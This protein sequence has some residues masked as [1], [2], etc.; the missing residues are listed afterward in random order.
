MTEKYNLKGEEK[1]LFRLRSLYSSFGY[2]TYKMS[3]F[4]EYDLY[5]RNKDFLVSSNIITFN[6]TD[7]KLLALKPDVTL[8]IVRSVKD[9]S[10]TVSRICYGE[11][12]Y[13][14]SSSSGTFREIMQAGLECIGDVGLLELC[15]VA[16]LAQMSL[17]SI[18]KNSILTISHIGIVE[19]LLNQIP[20]AL[21]SEA[22]K[23]LSGRSV[24]VLEDLSEKNPEYCKPLS[25]IA[26]LA[27]ISG[28]VDE[29]F[30]QLSDME[31][32]EK[33]LSELR[34]IANT[35][36]PKRM[37]ID[38]SILDGM[39]YYNGIVFRGYVQG[40]PSA[41][42]SGGQYDKLMKRMKRKS[43]AIG[44]A[45]YLDSLERLLEDVPEYDVDVVLK[46]SDSDDI[47]AVLKKAQE[48]R[49]SGKSVV[50]LKEPD[51]SLRYR[52]LVD[53]GGKD[54]A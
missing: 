45:V 8:S 4:E 17:A 50:T 15:E 22:A 41:V 31:V 9:K 35:L 19:S 10:N 36:D 30:K 34:T 44:F 32:D 18:S 37:R 12:V 11:N 52:D 33:S 1:V 43:R 29:V 53:M 3:R 38:F 48:I 54:N 21:A 46:Y 16:S 49:N 51:E 7:G 5:A 40:V 6:D 20:E 26:K 42:I 39:K 23:A 27:M 24:S 25:K 13:R 28:S 14:V 2:K 47:K